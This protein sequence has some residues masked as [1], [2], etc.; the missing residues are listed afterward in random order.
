M[1]SFGFSYSKV[2][3]WYNPERNNSKHYTVVKKHHFLQKLMRGKRTTII[4]A[5]EKI[6]TEIL[7]KVLSNWKRCRLWKK[8]NWQKGSINLLS[9]CGAILRRM[10]TANNMFTNQNENFIFRYV[11]NKHYFLECML[12]QKILALCM[13]IKEYDCIVAAACLSVWACLYMCLKVL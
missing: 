8:K 5:I 4:D 11:N 12:S 6:V 10:I 1:K 9:F 3:W 7:G 13:K 2:C